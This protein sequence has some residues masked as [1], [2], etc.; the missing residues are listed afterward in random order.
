MKSIHVKRNST[1]DIDEFNKNA[2]KAHSIKSTKRKQGITSS[3]QQSIHKHKHKPKHIPK[4]SKKH[5]HNSLEDNKMNRSENSNKRS[6][7]TSVLESKTDSLK[8][9]Q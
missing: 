7:S 5:I 2:S 3:T 8:I 9:I 6:L 1:K 4:P